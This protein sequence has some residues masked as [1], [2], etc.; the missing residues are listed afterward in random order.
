MHRWLL[1]NP[2]E[3]RSEVLPEQAK[4]G[5]VQPR[6][7]LELNIQYE[8]DDRGSFKLRQWR[9]TGHASFSKTILGLIME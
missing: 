2:R 5:Y 9:E 1:L 4:P 3:V 7:G 6:D 8:L